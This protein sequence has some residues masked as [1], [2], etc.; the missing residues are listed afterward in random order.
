MFR[1]E[2][3]RALFSDLRGVDADPD[4]I[5]FGPGTPE[6]DIF[7]EIAGAFEHWT[8]DD[9]VN[10]DFAAFDIFQDAFVGGG[11]TADVMV[12]GKAVNRDGDADARKLHPLDGNGNDGA[13][14][15]E[16][17]NIHA[18]ENRENAAEFLVAN[19]RLAADKR[20]VNRLM[21]ADE[22]DDAVD[23]SVAAKIVELPKS[24]FAAEMRV[25]VGIT[26][27]TG[28]R[29]FASDFDGEHGDFAGEDVAPG[30]QDFAL[31]YARVRH[32]PL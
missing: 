18:A 25:A 31:G 30:G 6:R 32:T 5:H 3:L 14:D 22:I 2:L 8:R 9:P 19:E 11:L 27:G 28:E 17:E 12:F 20:D 21:L 16:R 15:D 1:Q 4:T 10:V 13:G 23:E 24:G 7:I 26:A 29:T